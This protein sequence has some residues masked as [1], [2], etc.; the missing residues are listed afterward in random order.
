MPRSCDV[1]PLLKLD[2]PADRVIIFHLLCD[3]DAYVQ[4]DEGARIALH[5]GDIVTFPQGDAHI[6]GGGRLIKPMEARDALPTLMT[7]GLELARGGGGGPHFSRFICG[8]LACE[9]RLSRSFLDGLPPVLVVNVRHDTAGQWLENSLK[10]SVAEAV[11]KR[12]GAGG[13]LAKLSEVVFAETLRH[14]IRDLPEHVTGWLAGTR[15]PD[16]GRA[17]TILH[18][19]Y[20]EPWTVAALAREVGLSRTVLADR[21]RHFLDV[22]PM[23][24]LTRWRL[25]LG[26]RAL[27]T[28]SRGVAEIA[29]DVGYE[30]VA[31]F[32]RAFKREYGLPPVRYRKVRLCRD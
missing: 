21:F 7:Q 10:F 23:A 27:A 4:L 32:N 24:Y 9:P 26:A 13:V 20:A 11:R 29:F 25:R 12:P 14:Y 15:D 17:L 19:R 6:L 30:S 28:S 8:F 16:V 2:A 31:A 1:A 3:G 22:P 18:R 5:A